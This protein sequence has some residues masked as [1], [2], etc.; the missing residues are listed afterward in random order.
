MLKQNLFVFANTKE[1]KTGDLCL[2][3]LFAIFI[4]LASTRSPIR[5]LALGCQDQSFPIRYYRLRPHV[6]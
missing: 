2:V 4:G 1:H 3:C 5:F 6:H